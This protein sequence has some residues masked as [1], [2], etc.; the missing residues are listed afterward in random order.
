MSLK[1]GIHQK[2]LSTLSQVWS[3]S[4]H[5]S[6]K[7]GTSFTEAPKCTTVA[8]RSPTHLSP[9]PEFRF[10]SRRRILAKLCFPATRKGVS[11]VIQPFQSDSNYSNSKHPIHLR[12][13]SSV[14]QTDERFS[15]RV[16][17]FQ[18]GTAIAL[19]NHN[20]CTADTI[21]PV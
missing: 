7:L 1:L 14:S 15:S 10:S 13:F 16:T 9:H 12:Q 5:S 6:R 20:L 3:F 4:T 11:N 2:A 19:L 18:N 8:L 17:K 21:S